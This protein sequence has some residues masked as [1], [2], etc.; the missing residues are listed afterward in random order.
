IGIASDTTLPEILDTIPGNVTNPATTGADHINNI[1]Q[2]II[3]NPAS[4]TYKAN[5][6]GTAITQNSPQEYFL[7]Y[8]IIPVS[9][10]LTH[11]I[12]GE[13]LVQGDS[14][15]ISWDSYG[16]P[17]NPFTISYSTDNGAT[18]TDTTAPANARQLKWF[19]PSVVTDK[20][21]I[22]I[23]RNST[24]MTSTSAAFTIIG[25]PVDTLTPV[26][27][28]GYIS[29]GWKSING[30][31]DYEIMMLQGSEM[32]SIGTTTDSSYIISGL[33]KDSLYWVS[34][35]ARLNG[36]PGRRSTAIF[37]QPN[38]G[39]CA[40]NISDNDLK[41]DAILSPVSGR[42]F[43][44]T[45]L[46]AAKTIS[47]RIKN[48][49]DAAI[50]RYALKYS[51]NGGA[52]VTDSV[53]TTVAGGAIDTHDFTTTYDFSAVGTY[54]LKV[55]VVN[56]SAVD[57]VSANDTLTSVIKQLDNPAINLTTDF[58]DNIEAAPEQSYTTNQVGL[59][60]LDRYDFVT[61][62]SYGRIRSFVNSG[63]AYSGSKALTL[64]ADRYN[65][66]TTDSLTA[67]F[68]I[69]TYDTA[70]DDIRLDFRYKNHG[71]TQNNANQV[72]VRGNDSQ[73]WIQV[74]DLYANQNDADGSYKK[75]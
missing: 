21:K 40:G 14:I 73:P 11:P 32:V 66:G 9:T 59:M 3:N 19:A 36:N 10:T 48:L 64:D 72:W 67:T 65:T 57:P 8:D 51:V 52:W 49:D 33:S 34:V 37:R 71:Q 55:V 22:R 6:L 74:Y 38:S 35:R 42:K 39:T 75:T 1:E 62:S 30:A 70:T 50:T 13:K 4:G 25:S 7:V 31:T 44:S 28:E 47:A 17:V 68:N 53:F 41:V 27:C 12:G 5:V 20:A 61:S 23:T 24:A 15:Y 26:Q 46:S 60:G 45:E 2:V 16:D 58:L 56:L 54:T 18:W 69:A 43:T 29:L 63:I